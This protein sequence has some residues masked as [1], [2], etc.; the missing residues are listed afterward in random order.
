MVRV[1][2]VIVF[3]VVTMTVV[4]PS[5]R[6]G[7]HRGEHSRRRK[8]LTAP[9]APDGARPLAASLPPGE[10]DEHQDD[11]DEDDE[12]GH[13]R[14]SSAGSGCHTDRRTLPP[15]CRPWFGF[16]IQNAR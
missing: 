12:V 5:G 15:Q 8:A 13:A 14:S 9:L 4:T 10:D 11:E 2:S 16:R 7:V 6:V 3:V 1:V